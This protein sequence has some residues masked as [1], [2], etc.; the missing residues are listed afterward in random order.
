MNRIGT[1]TIETKR[2][3]L[4]RI[5]PEDYEVMY[6]NWAKY[7]SVC[8]YFPFHPIEDI[9]IYKEKVRKWSNNYESDT[10][11]HWVIEWKENK[12]LIGTINLGNVEE[13]CFMSDT[14][15]MLSPAYWGMG[16]MTEVLHAVLDYA[17]NKIELNRVQAEV[18]AG[19]A[20]SEHVL[21]K[22]GM[23]YEGT[24]RQKY[25]KNETFID[26][27]QYAILKQDCKR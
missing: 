1:K 20:A 19:N 14:C 6:H 10:Y 11:F 2:C 25:F 18:Y 16:I 4:R 12:E 22:C 5:F 3:I 13:S 8:R 15:Y 26:A 21:V 27:A 24:A 9:E 7:E 17:F 23:Q